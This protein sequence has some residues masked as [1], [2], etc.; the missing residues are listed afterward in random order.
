MNQSSMRQKEESD[1]YTNG[2]YVQATN[3]Y[4]ASDFNN[5]FNAAFGPGKENLGNHQNTQLQMPISKTGTSLAISG[6][7]QVFQSHLGQ[8]GGGDQEK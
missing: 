5:N 8:V 6:A 2:S 4:G 3:N 7:N 1:F